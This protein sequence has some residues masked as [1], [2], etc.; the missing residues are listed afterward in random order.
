[1]I[2]KD[3]NFKEVAGMSV[4]RR[5]DAEPPRSR[6]EYWQRI[7]EDTFGPAE[8][9]VCGELGSGDRLRVGDAGAVR[10]F[11]LSV[12]GRNEAE[13]RRTHIRR[14]DRELYKIA[15]HTR[16]HG[17]VEQDG[18]RTRLEPGD[19]IFADLSRPCHW[20]YSSAEFVSVAFPHTLLPLQE[21]QLTRLTGV[22]IPGDRGLGAL[23]SSLARQLPERLDDC[24]PADQARLGTAVLDL[25]TAA[26]AARLDRAQEVPPDSRRRALLL[27]LLAFIEEHLGD[28]ELSPAGI[29][30]AHHISLSYLYKLFETEQTT[31][32]DWIRRRRLERCRRDLLDPALWHTPVST[33]A[34]RWGFA[35]PAHFSRTFRAA[36][37]LPPRQYRTLLTETGAD[38]ASSRGG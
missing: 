10:V 6:R 13:R 34:A 5:A 32:A 37:G 11:E 7:L 35:S 38:R 25:V 17:V 20:A 19:L 23:V 21:K 29:A 28:P 12:S 9:R 16:G 3:H 2:G 26:L 27:R 36:H 8:L 31:V 14:L 18:R 24:G 22:R 15:V 33:I 30:A 1:L 4:V